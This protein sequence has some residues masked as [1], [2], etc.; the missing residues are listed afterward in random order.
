[1]KKFLL[2]EIPNLQLQYS[3]V[4]RK[5]LFV[6][7]PDLLH[8]FLI[9]CTLTLKID[10]IIS[11]LNYTF[12]KILTEIQDKYNQPLI[13]TLFE[14]CFMLKQSIMS[15]IIGLF[16]DGNASGFTPQRKL[17]I[18][19]HFILFFLKKIMNNVG[20]CITKNHKQHETAF[21]CLL[22]I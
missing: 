3:N 15:D 11:I 16:I 5:F 14:L 1:M 20:K 9:N 19:L 22:H 21:L 6:N 17:Q 10:I 2:K 8:V 18:Q 12:N 13:I 4:T 7:W